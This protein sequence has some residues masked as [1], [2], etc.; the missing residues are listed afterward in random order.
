MYHNRFTNTMER[1]S[2]IPI[3]PHANNNNITT[4]SVINSSGLVSMPY[5]ERR[6]REHPKKHATRIHLQC[7]V[8]KK[9]L[10]DVMDF[11]LVECGLYVFGYDTCKDSFWGKKQNHLHFT[12]KIKNINSVTQINIKIIMDNHNQMKQVCEK[13]AELVHIYEDTFV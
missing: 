4:V 7:S 8:A 6:I 13:I 2:D 11:I 10:H 3:Q 12:L 5:K 9:H 1:I